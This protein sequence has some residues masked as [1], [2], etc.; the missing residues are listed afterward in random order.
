MSENKV[1]YGLKNVHIAVRTVTGGKATYAT[2][3]KLNGAVNLSLP[4]KGGKIEF[5]AD[6]VEYFK[7][8]N[9]Q[10]YEGTL[11]VALINEEFREKVLKEIKDENGVAFESAET[12]FADF[13]MM[14]EFSGD[15]TKTRHILY[16]CSV[17][18][19]NLE[20]QTRAAS[21]EVRTETLNITAS[22]DENGIVKARCAEGDDA[23]ENWFTTV[24]EK[25]E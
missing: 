12:V 1:K 19:P 10:G 8:Y 7:A 17:E 5:Y 11:E 20:S 6:D 24:Y 15:A 25:T 14:F 23:Y 21:V 22:A 16:N 13:A 9:N 18:R 4:P 3:F 2:P